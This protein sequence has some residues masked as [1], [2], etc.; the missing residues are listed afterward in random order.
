MEWAVF[1]DFPSSPDSL[2]AQVI[3]LPVL[4]L[5]TAPRQLET[6]HVDGPSFSFRSGGGFRDRQPRLVLSLE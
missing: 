4:R 6:Y 3:S 2:H 5:N 1:Q